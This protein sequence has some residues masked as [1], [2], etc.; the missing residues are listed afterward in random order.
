MPESDV[1]IIGSGIAGLHAAYPLVEGG[2]R[3][4]MLDVG[5]DESHTLEE[6]VPLS[7][8]EHRRSDA[9]QDKIFLGDDLSGIGA[10]TGDAGHA[11][12]MTSGRRRYIVRGADTHAPVRNDSSVITQSLASGGLSEAWG[13]V[14]GF[15]DDEELRSVGIPPE[16]MKTHYAAII[17]RIGVS[18]T[19]AKHDLQSPAEIDDNSTRILRT[20]LSRK[21]FFDNMGFRVEQPALALL[22][23]DKDGRRATAYRDMDFW[24]NIG[25]SIYRGHYTLETLRTYPNFTYVPDIFVKTVRQES[26]AVIVVTK[27]TATHQD[28]RFRAK[29]LIMAAG[30]INTTR[31]LLR[32]FDLFDTPVPLILKNNYLIPNLLLSRLGHRSDPHRH[33]LCQL[34][35]SGTRHGGNPVNAYVQLYSYK[36]LLL[37]KLLRYVP[38]PVPEALSVL[39]LITPAMVLADVRFP[40]SAGTFGQSILRKD[41]SGDHLEITHTETPAHKTAQDKKI[42]PIKRALRALGLLPLTSVRNP[43][44]ATSHYAGGVPYSESTVEH[45]L[46]VDRDGRLHQADRIYVADAA[47]WASLPAKPPALTIM[48]NANRIGTRLKSAILLQ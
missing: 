40:M 47:S 13:A 21:P 30:A 38:L 41:V 14:C 11:G 22:T 2:V 42:K 25:R 43:F 35:M 16:E 3:V 19:N 8:E 44:G 26:A 45:V 24:D 6:G 5:L 34:I 17:K 4:T 9:G 31:I 36:S 32:S 1:I 46:S 7:F 37:Y 20:F 48:A 33:S 27:N 39:S 29:R 23:R 28:I 12:A 18:G 15:F 10:S